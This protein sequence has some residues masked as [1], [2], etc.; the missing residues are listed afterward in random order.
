MAERSNLAEIRNKVVAGVI[1]AVVVGLLWWLRDHL[2]VAA[3][4]VWQ[5]TVGVLRCLRGPL[6]APLWLWLLQWLVVAAFF[7][8]QYRRWLRRGRAIREPLSEEYVTDEY[9]G[10]LWRWTYSGGIIAESD[11]QCWCGHCDVGMEAREGRLG[12]ILSDPTC[13]IVSCPRCR[14]EKTLYNAYHREQNAAAIE[15]LAKLRDGRWRQAVLAHR[16]RHW[17]R[18]VK[19]FVKQLTGLW[20]AHKGR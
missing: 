7:F 5:L 8:D 18:N 14:Q 6:S 1:T 10:V 2:R 12:L 13:T 20:R 19:R 11:L 3:I 15:F 9:H 16:E 4:P 17:G